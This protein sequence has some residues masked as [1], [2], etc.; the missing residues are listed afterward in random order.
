MK[1]LTGEYA[2]DHH[3]ASQCDP[4]YDLRAQEWYQPWYAD[5][6]DGLAVPR[7]AWPSEVVGRVTADAAEVT[8]LPALVRWALWTHG[9]KR[10]AP[11]FAG[12]AIPRRCMARRCSSFKY[13]TTSPHI[14]SCG[15]PQAS[16]L[17]RTHSQQGC[18]PQAASRHGSRTSSAACRSMIWSA[19]PRAVPPGSGGLLLLPYFTGERTPIFDPRAP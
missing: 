3:T 18:P 4:L 1:R 16:T 7:L 11:A 12:R 8:H 10:S 15:R 2:L 13:S 5:V 9:L 6:M 17:V 14:R 19:R